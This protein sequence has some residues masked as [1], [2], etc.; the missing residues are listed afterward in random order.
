MSV[1]PA[2]QL[3][4]VAHRGYPTNY[5]ENTLVGYR[6]AIQAG[7]QWIETDIQLTRDECPVLYHD[8]DLS[9]VSGQTGQIF[10]QSS[11]DL[12]AL[13]ASHRTRFGD[14]FWDEGI[15]TLEQFAE[16][17]VRHPSVQ[18]MVELKP[19]SIDRFSAD[20][21]LGIVHD[22]LSGLAEQCVII[23]LDPGVVTLAR[24]RHAWRMGWVLSEWTPT[25]HRQ[26]ERMRP[27]FLF[28]STSL[29]TFQDAIPSGPWDWAIY[30]I[31]DPHQAAA[32][33]ARG[34]SLVETDSIGDMLQDERLASLCRTARDST[35]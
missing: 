33:W 9:R 23:S 12:F 28:A 14:Q 13:S 29:L 27:D 20:T 10:E 22:H 26:A 5:P 4:L 11:S 31:D 30:S 1:T 17:L 3:N 8:V 34:I 2:T 32:Q 21:M 18:A 24:S 19:E 7:A 15:A 16:L 6:A 35:S 25:V